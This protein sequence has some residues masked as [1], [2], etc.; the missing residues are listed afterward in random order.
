VNPRGTSSE[1]PQCGGALHHPSWRRSDCANCQSSWHRDRAAAIVILSRGL[2]VLRGAAPPPR[3]RDA[4]REA[5]AWRP[6]VDDKSS[7][8]PTTLPTNGDDAKNIELMRPRQLGEEQ[9]S[10]VSAAPTRDYGDKR[11][12]DWRQ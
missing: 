6:G 11:H 7:S 3:A 2:G 8:G 1:C 12:T 10:D 5:A 4:L 9:L